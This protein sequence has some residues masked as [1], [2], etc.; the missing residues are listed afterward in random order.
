MERFEKILQ[1]YK[2]ISFDLD[3][4]LVHTLAAY[5]HKIVP[6]VVNYPI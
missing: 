5:R 3:G 4:T 2:H 1:E 6:D